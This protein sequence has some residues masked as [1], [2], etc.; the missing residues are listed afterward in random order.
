MVL[1]GALESRTLADCIV[2]LRR[3]IRSCKERH[4]YLQLVSGQYTPVLRRGG[5]DL[6]FVP[7]P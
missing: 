1:A 4:V 6:F 3:G 7:A 5:T 2:S